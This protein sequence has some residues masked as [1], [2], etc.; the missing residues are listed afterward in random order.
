MKNKKLS[1]NTIINGIAL[2]FSVAFFIASFIAA[3]YTRQWGHVFH[4]WYQIMTSPCPLV[5]DY[6]EIGGLAS[7]FLN[8]GACGMVCFLFMVGLKGDSHPNT[9]AGFFLVVAHCFYGLNLL[10]MLPCF[11]APFIYLQRKKLNYN[12]NL[13]ICMFCTSFGPFVSEFLFR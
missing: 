6:L 9:M 3:I 2:G 12:D 13:H 11:I 8:A 4:N 7:A 5:T 10:N 1:N